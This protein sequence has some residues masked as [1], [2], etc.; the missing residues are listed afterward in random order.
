MA[1][2]YDID[3]RMHISFY[4]YK[5]IKN[6]E[7]IKYQIF[8]NDSILD[9]KNTIIFNEES[10]GE[11]LFLESFIEPEVP[12]LVK[13]IRQICFSK[14]DYF[15][16]EPI[17]EKDF[18]LL[19]ERKNEAVKIELILRFEEYDKK[20]SLKAKKEN[21]LEFADELEQEYKS[22][23]NGKQGLIKI[24]DMRL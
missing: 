9:N 2:M 1:P 14:I 8:V 22:V 20:F 15:V 18:C 21:L 17:D 11:E 10:A 12:E 6:N 23:I 13:C 5:D 3:N 16:F 4:L 24:D 19:M 7:W